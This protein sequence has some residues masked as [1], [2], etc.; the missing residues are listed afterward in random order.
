MKRYLLAGLV[1]L[2]SLPS[3]AQCG[4]SLGPKADVM[5]G[6]FIPETVPTRKVVPYTSLVERDVM[7]SKRV[8]RVIDLREKM[9]LPMYYPLEPTGRYA[10]LWDIIKCNVESG[11]ITAYD[12]G[13]LGDD[14]EFTMPLNAAEFRALTYNVDTLWTPDIDN[15]DEL[16][17]VV[18]PDPLESHEIQ[19]YLVKEDWFFDR[20][21]SV[22][23]VRIIGIA[24]YKEVRGDDGEL[25]GFAAVCWIYF[26]ELRYVLTNA[27]V[28]NR[29][30]PQNNTLSY[31][32][33][34]M[35]RYF[36]S[37]IVKESNVYNR[38]INE[39]YTGKAALIEAEEIKK[40]LM[41]VEHDMWH[42]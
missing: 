23:D 34:F 6:A 12:P 30:N 27:N 36:S 35:K 24:P 16:M 20:Q 11:T 1:L 31:D 5:T 18:Q 13:P 40:D 28:F 7:W 37:Y 25:R 42:F 10:S 38:N 21:R 17:P 4:Y 8:W 3:N 14:D 22:M 32:D 29:Q 19:R 26:P 41:L 2:L 33:L 9:N 15:P 39:I